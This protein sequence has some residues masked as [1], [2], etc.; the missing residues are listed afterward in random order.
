MKKLKTIIKELHQLE[1][2]L[3]CYTEWAAELEYQKQ[4]GKLN[5]PPHGELKRIRML[6]NINFR[7]CHEGKYQIGEKQCK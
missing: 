5:I 3:E 6:T 2:D 4:F 1:E 7:Y